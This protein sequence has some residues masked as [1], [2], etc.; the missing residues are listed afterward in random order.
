MCRGGCLPQTC[1]FKGVGATRNP[2]GFPPAPAARQQDT[3]Q[4]R[5]TAP[6]PAGSNASSTSTACRRDV[7]YLNP[8]LPLPLAQPYS[9]PYCSSGTAW[10][11]NTTTHAFPFGPVILRYCFDKSNAPVSLEVQ[12]ESSGAAERFS[13]IDYNPSAPAA[14]TFTPPTDCTCS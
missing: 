7:S 12:D 14:S 5:L 11:V 6:V 13:F 1:D 4:Q 9:D 2:W 8:F 3:P 10:A